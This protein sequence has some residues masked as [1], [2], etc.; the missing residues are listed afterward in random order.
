MWQPVRHGNRTVSHRL[1][2]VLTPCSAVPS[3]SRDSISSLRLFC[4]R[5]HSNRN[6]H[7]ELSF[8]DWTLPS[9]RPAVQP[10]LSRDWSITYSHR[11]ELTLSH[12]G[13][14]A[15][16]R[17]GPSILFRTGLSAGP[18]GP[19][20]D[21]RS[22]VGADRTRWLQ[23][24]H[25]VGRPG[26]LTALRAGLK[27]VYRTGQSMSHPG[28]HGTGPAWAPSTSSQQ[29]LL[30]STSQIGDGLDSVIPAFAGFRIV[31]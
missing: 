15:G 16:D 11:E 21:Q 18:N 3:G 19:S 31:R 5:I 30:S 29:Q 13:A 8:D 26:G 28:V 9:V 7:R 20:F 24:D 12:H 1:P 2:G 4:D 10:H 14:I 17:I 27:T 6:S 23:M 22:A 25:P